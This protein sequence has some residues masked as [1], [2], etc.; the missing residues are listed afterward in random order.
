MNVHEC[1]AFFKDYTDRVHHMSAKWM[2]ET[3]KSE[4]QFGLRMHRFASHA[5]AQAIQQELTA[6][7]LLYTNK[8]AI[9]A[10]SLPLS[11]SPSRSMLL[12]RNTERR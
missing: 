12:N 1:L 3:K 7:H 10:A 5:F 2:K 8:V 9:A 11:T 6:R 4:V